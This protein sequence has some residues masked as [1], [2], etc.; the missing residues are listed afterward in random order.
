VTSGVV[1][2]AVCIVV[3]VGVVEVDETCVDIV[4]EENVGVDVSADDV[5]PVEL[6]IGVN[7]PAF[8]YVIFHI[9]PATANVSVSSIM[10]RIGAEFM[11]FLAFR[12]DICLSSPRTVICML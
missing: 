7:V 4:D 9:K 5:V 6:S 3:V 1:D 11:P 12:E 10:T 8:T 2:E